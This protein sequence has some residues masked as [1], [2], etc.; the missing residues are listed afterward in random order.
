MALE[1]SYTVF[2][3]I[4]D[5]KMSI[6]HSS[7]SFVYLILLA[8]FLFQSAF[9][10]NFILSEEH[11]YLEVASNLFYYPHGMMLKDT[12]GVYLSKPPLLFWMLTGL[13]KIFGA[14]NSVI[15][16]LLMSILAAILYFSQYLYEILFENSE[17]AK[18]VPVIILGS[19]LFFSRSTVFCFDSLVVLFFVLSATGI[20]LALKYFYVRGFFLYGFAVGLGVL[21]KGPIILAFCLPFLAVATFLRK[22]YQVQNRAWFLGVLL[23][24][25]IAVIL[26]MIWLAPV[27]HELSPRRRYMLL[28]HRGFGVGDTYGRVPFYFYIKAFFLLFLP[29]LIWPY[30]LKSLFYS[31]KKNNN[32]AF[33]LVFYSL[34]L[35][36]IILSLIPPKA[37]RY[38]MSSMILFSLLYVYALFK[39]KFVYYSGT[40]ELLILLTSIAAGIELITLSSPE[41]VMS[42]ISYPAITYGWI[43]FFE[44]L[45]VVSGIFLV[46]FK[47]GNIVFEAIRLCAFMC[48]LTISA[49]VFPHEVMSQNFGYQRFVEYLNEIKPQNIPIIYCRAYGG[50]QYSMTRSALPNA[51]YTLT[52]Q[53]SGPKKFVYFVEMMKKNRGPTQQDYLYRLIDPSQTSAIFVR[54]IAANQFVGLSFKEQRCVF[55]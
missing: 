21:S 16:F 45:L 54:K 47:R 18:L 3:K 52:E 1:L 23:S 43:L 27:L 29:W 12:M 55:F 50:Y 8:V 53:E 46:N 35:S 7:C 31:I 39:N 5:K 42:K 11:H 4:M 10:P 22:K 17:Q 48:V 13:W 38:A 44:S 28:F 25:L 6:K 2:S 37:L 51:K 40:R 26:I 19:F 15:H 14:H 30:G 34:L 36:L 24:L 32:L 33:K 41:W 20:A 49:T 9:Y